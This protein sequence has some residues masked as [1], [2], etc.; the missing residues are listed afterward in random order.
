M[1]EYFPDNYPWSMATLMAV[2]AGGIMS[3]IDDEINGL[4]EIASKNDTSANEKWLKAWCVLGERNLA[5]A[6][7]DANSGK[8]ISAG[9][10]FF[11]ASTYFMTGERMCSSKSILKLKTYKKMLECFKLGLQYL[12][13]PLKRID[14]PFG[15]NKLPALFYP[16]TRSSDN[17]PAPCI[18]HFDGL[19]VMKEFLFLIG[20]PH[21]YAKRGISTLL[22]DHP[23]VG[24]A[25]RLHDLKLT[26]ETEKP[27]GAAIDYLT[28]LGMDNINRYINKLQL[29][30]FEKLQKI[31]NIKIYGDIKGKGAIISFN[32]K[33]IHPHDIAHILDSSGIAIRA[34][35]HC[36]QPLMNKLDVSSTNRVSLYI[37]NSFAEVDKLIISLNKVVEV[38]N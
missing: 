11:R 19:D 22:L 25:L 32:I 16:A 27:A 9:N 33:N 36:A 20:L 13:T 23:G 21:E 26:P 5:L 2:N 37:Y 7:T 14:V 30:A 24:E 28:E 38:F 15:D 12:E 1:F 6:L 35:H 34:G 4:K 3:E 29:Y 17:N 18:I 31:P 10:K 8:N